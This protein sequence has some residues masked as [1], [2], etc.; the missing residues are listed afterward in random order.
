MRTGN[1]DGQ[2]ALWQAQTEKGTGKNKGDEN[3]PSAGAPE[4]G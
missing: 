3:R 2:D 1:A 4:M